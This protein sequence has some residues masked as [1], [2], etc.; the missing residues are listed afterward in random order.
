MTWP[1]IGMWP[2]SIFFEIYISYK[3]GGF[4][5]DGNLDGNV[6]IHRQSKSWSTMSAKS[7]SR[8]PPDYSHICF[9]HGSEVKWF[10]R[11][12]EQK[13]GQVDRNYH[14]IHNFP[15]S[16]CHMIGNHCLKLYLQ[17]HMDGQKLA[18][19]IHHGWPSTHGRPWVQKHC[20]SL[21]RMEGLY[22]CLS[23]NI[24]IQHHM[25]HMLTSV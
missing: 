21:T 1:N 11:E 22:L 7:S 5:L 13:D 24:T 10:S 9:K 2:S 8:S 25:P 6:S 19:S 16:Q 15:V 12:S 18:A 23:G 14:Y 17:T 3:F 20:T 4:N